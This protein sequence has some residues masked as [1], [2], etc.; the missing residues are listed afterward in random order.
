MPLII[1]H[2]REGGITS[3]FNS[4]SM[5]ALPSLIPPLMRGVRGESWIPAYAGMTKHGFLVP[6]SFIALNL[7]KI[8]IKRDKT[9]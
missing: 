3:L 2:S 5:R 6:Y 8:L 7:A 4:P 1:R 9:S